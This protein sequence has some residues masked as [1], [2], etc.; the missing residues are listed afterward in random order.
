MYAGAVMRNRSSLIN[1]IVLTATALLLRVI[2]IYLSAL[3]SRHIGAEG[4]GLYQ[5]IFSVYIF[6][7]ALS[8]SGFSQAVSRMA[9]E[10]VESGKPGHLPAI[11]R[12]SCALGVAISAVVAAALIASS[13]PVAARFLGD[14]RAAQPLR[15][16]AASLP[17]VAVSAC[18]RGYFVGLRQAPKSAGASLFEQLFRLAVTI[19]LLRAAAPHGIGRACNAVVLAS[20][21]AE[22]ASFLFAYALYR[23]DRKKRRAPSSPAPPRMLG[24]IA[25]IALPMATS[26]TLRTGLRTAESLLIPAGLR[27]SGLHS[28]TALTQYGVLSGMV[29]PVLFF[30][31]SLLMAV[32]M[33]MVPE[34]ARAA[35]AGSRRRVDAIASRAVQ[36]TLLMSL[37]VAAVFAVFSEELTMALYGN[38][39]AGRVLRMLSPLVPLLYLDHVVDAML[40]GMNEQMKTLQYNT[41]DSALR[42]AMIVTLT[43]LMGMNGYI[44]TLF[45]S[46]IFNAGLSIRRLLR[47]SGLTIRAADWVIKPLLAALLSAVLAS[48]FFRMAFPGLTG[49]GAIA[50]AQ[51]A[52]TALLYAGLLAVSGCVGR[53]DIAWMA[54]FFKRAGADR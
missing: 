23:R 6:A 36:V 32:S 33:L 30:P 25:A 42:L 21:L 41:A 45:V 11:V 16:M 39:A 24:R 4:L 8:S 50:A 48:L 52:L 10:A 7:S 35:A 27:R 38:R 22:A 9:A 26:A 51:A 19:V 12:Q 54:G 49:S 34:V 47:V 29:M 5:L 40:I 1:F 20:T 46:T 17:F 28:G 53:A 31:A 2:G 14:G 15:I 37:L 44:A 13:E 43:P 3:L 18:L